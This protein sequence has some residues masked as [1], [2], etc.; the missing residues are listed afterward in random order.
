MYLPITRKP[1]K[2]SLIHDCS[3]IPLLNSF[4]TIPILTMLTVIFVSEK[5][6]Y[7]RCK[8]GIR[9]SN[10]GICDPGWS[11]RATAADGENGFRTSL[12]YIVLILCKLSLSEHFSAFFRTNQMMSYSRTF[13]QSDGSPLRWLLEGL[14]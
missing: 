7:D 5:R 6:F 11:L 14:K 12:L 13:I 8:P 4:P 2:I 1:M 9:S 3:H 10:L